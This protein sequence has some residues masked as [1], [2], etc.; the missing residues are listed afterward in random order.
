MRSEEYSN[1]NCLDG[2]IG[3]LCEACDLEGKTTSDGAKYSV[4]SSYTCG[5][6]DDVSTNAIKVAVMNLWVL[7]SMLLA[8]KGTIDLI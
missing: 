2:N 4:F 7:L 3:A 6:C 8:V 5:R 1:F